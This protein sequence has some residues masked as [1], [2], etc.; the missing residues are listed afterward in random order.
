MK[1]LR[2]PEAKY[3]EIC[4]KFRKNIKNGKKFLKNC[5]LDFNEILIK[6]DEIKKSHSNFEKIVVR[7]QTKFENIARS[8]ENFEKM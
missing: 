2:K 3:E 8:K 6:F 4:S 1:I 5:Y 7:F